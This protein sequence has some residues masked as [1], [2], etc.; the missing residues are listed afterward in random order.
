MCTKSKCC[1]VS[2]NV[3]CY[4]SSDS[5]DVSE[6]EGLSCG[7]ATAWSWRPMNCAMD[8]CY[9]TR[10]LHE[11]TQFIMLFLI[12][13]WIYFV[14]T[15]LLCSNID[16]DITTNLTSH[17]VWSVTSFMECALFDCHSDDPNP[18]V[19][20]TC[21]FPVMSLDSLSKSH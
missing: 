9:S 3:L 17:F 18:S 10:F 19:L 5:S 2:Y 12:H 8:Y 6:Y 15:W 21:G 7:H 1:E 4:N 16:Y 20:V 11:L 14:I 13:M